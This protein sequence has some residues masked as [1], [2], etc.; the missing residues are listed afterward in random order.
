MENVAGEGSLRF[1]GFTSRHLVAS[2]C[3]AQ[4]VGGASREFMTTRLSF[5]L[6]MHAGRFQAREKS[7]L[8]RCPYTVCH[9]TIAP[10]T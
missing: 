8:P 9:Q 5:V 3:K 1:L 4:A 7:I 10:R 6:I 2:A